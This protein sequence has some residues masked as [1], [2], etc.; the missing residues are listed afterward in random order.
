MKEAAERIRNDPQSKGT[1]DYLTV[2]L[3]DLLSV[4]DFTKVLKTRFPSIQLDQFIQNSG[5]WPA[6]HSLSVQGYEIAIATNVLGPHLLLRLLQSNNLLKN[7]AKIIILTGDIYITENDCTID[8][9]G[10]DDGGTKAYSRS[11]LGVNWMFFE[12][13]KRFPNYWCNLVHPGVGST[14]LAGPKSSFKDAMLCSANECAQTTLIVST[15]S[16]TDGLLQNG[17]YYHN[18]CGRMILNP[19]DPAADSIRGEIFYN[20]VEELIKSYLV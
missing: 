7:D 13:H 18:T 14:E 5:V 12:F 8:F 11:K 2:D 15:S 6:K 20:Q 9:E 4:V 17:A 10:L 19:A 1:I 3:S 16:K